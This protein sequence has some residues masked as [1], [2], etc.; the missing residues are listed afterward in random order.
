MLVN[1]QVD[2]TGRFQS[3]TT[4]PLDESAPTLELADDFDVSK[5]HDQMLQDGELVYDRLPK[6]ELEPQ[7]NAYVTRDDLAAVLHEGVNSI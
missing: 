4:F 5:I 6:P 3:V 1:Y 7:Q 2:E